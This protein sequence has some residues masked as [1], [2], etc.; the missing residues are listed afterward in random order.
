M[1]TGGRFVGATGDLSSGRA[2]RDPYEATSGSQ[3][4]VG[5]HL[6]QT[7]AAPTVLAD[8]A[9]DAVREN[10]FYVLSPEGGGWRRACEIRLDDIR[11][12]RNPTYVA[13]ASND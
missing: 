10:R 8:R 7:G 11:N 12:E 5:S 4:L 3:G 13:T 6:T 9:L 1:T 2:P